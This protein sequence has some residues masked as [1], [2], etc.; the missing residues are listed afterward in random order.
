MSL[1]SMLR[2]LR[3]P[4]SQSVVPKNRPWIGAPYRGS[5]Y[6]LD[7]REQVLVE[8]AYTRPDVDDGGYYPCSQEDIDILYSP[9]STR[10]MR[11]HPQ[12]FLR[13][14]SVAQAISDLKAFNRV[15]VRSCVDRD[16]IFPTLDEYLFNCRSIRDRDVP[17]LVFKAFRDLD[18]VFF[19][20]CLFGRV[21]LLW[22]GTGP[23]DR[24]SPGWPAGA[25]LGVT[26]ANDTGTDIKIT[27][28]VDGLLLRRVPTQFPEA[29]IL[30]EMLKTLLHE[31][32]VSYTPSS[33]S[34]NCCLETADARW[35]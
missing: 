35:I 22:A 21:Q 12:P 28:C 2:G 8:A 31:M 9:P 34:S 32:L 1:G 7:P 29:T 14:V 5:L 6:E 15:R 4:R 3:H 11:R 23:T 33:C 26:G 30:E 10:L 19:Q 13:K 17:A 27:L 18:N 24:L 20:S 25:T 16:Q